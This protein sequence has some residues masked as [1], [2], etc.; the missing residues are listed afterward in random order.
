MRVLAC[1]F[2][3]LLACARP[4]APTL[5][6][7]GGVSIREGTSGR[8]VSGYGAAA[9]SWRPAVHGL[10]EPQAPFVRSVRF[11]SARCRVRPICAWE[12]RQ[13]AR[14]LAEYERSR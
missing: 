10:D 6:L 4:A 13:R 8:A 3:V 7:L 5:H 9:V 2:L 12:E 11:R 14:V 1:S